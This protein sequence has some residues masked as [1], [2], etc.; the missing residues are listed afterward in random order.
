MG[1][2]SHPPRRPL[3]ISDHLPFNLFARKAEVIEETSVT[4]PPHVYPYLSPHAHSVSQLVPT[5]QDI[6]LSHPY[7]LSTSLG[8]SH[9]D[10][11]TKCYFSH[12]KSSLL[13]H[14][15]TGDYCLPGI[16]F[17]AELLRRAVTGSLQLFPPGHIQLV[18]C[19]LREEN[20]WLSGSAVVKGKVNESCQRNDETRNF[21]DW[22]QSQDNEKLNVDV[23]TRGAAGR[24]WT[25]QL[26]WA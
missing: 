14:S 25:H 15:L 8:Y 22:S 2:I 19:R 3:H 16:F 7:F 9:P 6:P 17:A 26:S 18:S 4:F 13:L 12:A 5:D 21:C 23:K 10:V 11:Q 24:C 20:T 1:P